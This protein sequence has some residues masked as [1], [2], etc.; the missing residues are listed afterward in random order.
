ML[1]FGESG[2]WSGYY[3]NAW[4]PIGSISGLE[5]GHHLRMNSVTSEGITC[6][7]SLDQMPASCGM[8]HLEPLTGT[9]WALQET[10]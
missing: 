3:F 5:E 4:E 1:A 9:D 6:V 7:F 2:C 10:G 8:E